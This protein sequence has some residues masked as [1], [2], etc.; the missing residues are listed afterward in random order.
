M[1][2]DFLTKKEY[3]ALFQSLQSK[4][5]ITVLKRPAK[6][7]TILANAAVA[8]AALD[9]IKHIR[10]S[11]PIFLASSEVQS[12]RVKDPIFQENHQTAKGI[13][14]S[15]SPDLKLIIFHEIST[16]SKEYGLPMVK[17]IADILPKDW[18]AWMFSREYEDFWNKIKRK[19]KNLYWVFD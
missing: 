9:F 2:E 5:T 1:P 10:I 16:D 17:C 11:G 15:F 19:H 7:P 4:A 3:D 12:G 18:K 13:F 6:I 8:M 14:V